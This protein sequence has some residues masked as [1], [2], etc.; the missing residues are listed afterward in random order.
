[1]RQTIEII[2]TPEGN[3]S[4]R[5]L[6]FVGPSCRDASRFLEEALGRSVG[7]QLT[8]EFHESQ[9]AHENQH[10]RT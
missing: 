8:A 9:P 3:T 6:G 4:V 7:E 5:T 1:M 10:E 2:V